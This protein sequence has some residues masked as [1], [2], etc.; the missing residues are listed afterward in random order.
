MTKIAAM[1]IYGKNLQTYP[2]QNQKSYDLEIWHVAL[3]T[4][5]L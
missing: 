3:G 5:V 1:P 2:L 4:K